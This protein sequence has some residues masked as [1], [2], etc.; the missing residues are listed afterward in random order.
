M[1][2]TFDE[3]W[4]IDLEGDN[5]GAR[6]T[7]N[8]FAIRTPVAIAVGV[9]YDEP[10]P[11]LPAVVHY[12]KI[13]G[14]QGDKFVKLNNIQGFADLK[15]RECLA[16]WTEPFLPKSDNAYWNW[17]LLTDVFPWQENGMQFKRSW[18]IGESQE[19]LNVRW[20][21]FLASTDRKLLF[22][23]TRDRKIDKSYPSLDNSIIRD[24]PIS[25]LQI[26]TN[27]PNIM[28]ISYRSFD[29][30]YALVDSR[31]GDY[32]RPTL[33][34]THSD[35][36]IYMTSLLTSVLGQGPSA[37]ATALI[38][39][40]H[41]FCNRGAK[42]IIP[43][44]ANAEATSANIT[45]GFS[46]VLSVLYKQTIP[47]ED[48]FA[49]C[50]AVL[51]N[52]SYVEKF[53]D[54]LTIPGPRIPFT[55]DYKLFN[56]VAS[57]GKKLIWL[58]TFGE[59]FIPIGNK[60][61]EVSQGIARCKVGTP[62]DPSSYPEQFSYDRTAQEIHIGMGIFDHVRPEVWDF[63]ISGFE[64]V[65]S[66]LAYR[67][68]DR[69][70]KSSSLLDEI[71]PESWQFDEELLDLLWVLDATIDMVP[72]VIKAL[73]TIINY[74]LLTTADFPK[75]TDSERGGPLA[76]SSKQLSL[77]EDQNETSEEDP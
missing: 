67:M 30:H 57:L 54:E 22:K 28:R 13:E 7:E 58:Q 40:M 68:R 23:E 63:S 12:S 24:I 70:G 15:W 34:R 76:G 33:Y 36:Q 65:K 18:P 64:V 74:P 25:K 10:R 42:D 8:I 4:I 1:R 53:W 3:L 21:H 27:A 35:K 45:H 52:P 41:H 9:R 75:P 6:K 66:W 38:P 37:V 62:S 48:L 44:W 73:D 5:L 43:L 47:A 19:V 77:A 26:N 46:E 14:T 50:Y 31:L 60:K 16:G 51:A 2:Q 61:G 49:Y 69:A 59:R 20:K 32:L 71:R 17:P 72:D 29:R 55:K 39:D 11:D 56:R